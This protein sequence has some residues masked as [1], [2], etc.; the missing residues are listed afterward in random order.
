MRLP[1]TN[2]TIY[3]SLYDIPADSLGLL[4][5]DSLGDRSVLVLAGTTLL[6]LGSGREACVGKRRRRDGRDKR[7]GENLRAAPLAPL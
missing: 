5:L 6:G 2:L 7:V 1:K 3:S 4:Q